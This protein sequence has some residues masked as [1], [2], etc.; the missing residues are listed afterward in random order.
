MLCGKQEVT[1][2]RLLVLIISSTYMIALKLQVSP[3]GG[4]HEV[5]HIGRTH[6]LPPTKKP[7]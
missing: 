5:Y 4:Y 1:V 7:A 6:H 2:N 3:T